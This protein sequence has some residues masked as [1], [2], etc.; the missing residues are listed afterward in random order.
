MSLEL[1]GVGKKVGAETHLHETS[2]TLAREGFN[3]LLGET[4]AGKTTLIKLMA[5]LEKPTTGGSGS[6][7]A[8]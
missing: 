5:G 6:T 1:R 3:V 7:A 8:T 4:G 2:L